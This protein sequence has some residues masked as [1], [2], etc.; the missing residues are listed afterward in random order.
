MTR[1]SLFFISVASWSVWIQWFVFNNIV[2]NREKL[3]YGKGMEPLIIVLFLWCSCYGANQ[4]MPIK[5]E[6]RHPLHWLRH[7]RRYKTYLHHVFSDICASDRCHS[8]HSV[9]IRFGI[10]FG[11]TT[12]PIYYHFPNCV[13]LRFSEHAKIFTRQFLNRYRLDLQNQ[14]NLHINRKPTNTL[15]NCMQCA[16]DE[17]FL[18]IL[19]NMWTVI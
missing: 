13:T 17:Y 9:E 8:E 7:K 5:P 19:Q 3:F 18:Q 4:V 10:T 15:T 16:F 1:W 14:W 6:L 12:L 2:R 11:P